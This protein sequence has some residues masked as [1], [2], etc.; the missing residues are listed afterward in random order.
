[1]LLVAL[2]DGR[3]VNDRSSIDA[4]I[5]LRALAHPTRRATVRHL[6]DAETY[7]VEW[8]PGRETIRYRSVEV[9]EDVLAALGEAKV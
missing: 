8:T 3:P 2:P 4:D 6:P 7:L 9:I 5:A 1:M